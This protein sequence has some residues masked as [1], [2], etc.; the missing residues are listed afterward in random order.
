MKVRFSVALDTQSR[1]LH[2]WVSQ[3]GNGS[4][5]GAKSSMLTHRMF[6][7]Q[8]ILLVILFQVHTLVPVAFVIDEFSKRPS[9][10]HIVTPENHLLIFVSSFLDEM[11]LY[12]VCL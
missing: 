9:R 2:S 11:M 4:A 10:P 12:D 8:C 1:L 5:S 3:R 6:S 7:S